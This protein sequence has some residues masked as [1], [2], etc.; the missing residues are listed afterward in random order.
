VQHRKDH[1]SNGSEPIPLPDL[2]ENVAEVTLSIDE[3]MELLLAAGVSV[4]DDRKTVPAKKKRVGKKDPKMARALRK[5]NSMGRKKSGGFKK[6][7][8]QG[9][10]MKKAHQLRRR[11]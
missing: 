4:R 6:G 10:I 7:W 2:G 1:S 3:Y 8:T 11:M 5:A 9:K